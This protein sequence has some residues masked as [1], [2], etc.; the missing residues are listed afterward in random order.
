MWKIKPKKDK[1]LLQ[2]YVLL[3]QQYNAS[4]HL[5]HLL[6]H[7]FTLPCFLPPVPPSAL[8][9]SM[10]DCPLIF[11]EKNNLSFLPPPLF[12]PRIK[13]YFSPFIS[14]YFQ[15]VAERMHTFFH[16]VLTHSIQPLNLVLFTY[17][18]KQIETLD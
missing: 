11:K 18:L 17:P 14:K 16:C 8:Q 5:A 15:R 10:I 7:N 13:F 9:K 1:G 6:A 3:E 2:K 4:F 12:Q